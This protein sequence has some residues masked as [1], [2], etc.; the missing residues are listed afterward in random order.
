MH[1][2]YSSTTV[3]YHC[4]NY[5][6]LVYCIQYDISVPLSVVRYVLDVRTVYSMLYRIIQ[7]VVVCCLFVLFVLFYCAVV[8]L[9]TLYSI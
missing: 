6:I 2:Q 3:L 7:P 1:V 9:Y 8:L 4:Y 5:S